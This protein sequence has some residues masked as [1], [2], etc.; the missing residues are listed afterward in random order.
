MDEQAAAAALP[1]SALPPRGRVTCQGFIESV[2]YQ[3]PS[4]HAYFSAVVTD[5]ES[6]RQRNAAKARLRVIW[7][8]RQRVPG[9]E[10]GVEVRLKGMVTER[11]GLPTMFNPR[12]DI[13]SRKEYQ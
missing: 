1:I 8:G 11:D 10:A 9:I 13:L 2:T 3:P 7:L 12:Y 6:V 5:S 4:E